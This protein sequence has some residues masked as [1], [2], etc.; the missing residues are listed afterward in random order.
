MP[1]SSDF[2]NSELSESLE[3]LGKI[4]TT[5][6]DH[7]SL[8]QWVWDG[9]I[10]CI[11]CKFWAYVE[12]AGL[13]AKFWN[14]TVEVYIYSF[15]YPLTHI[16]LIL[17]ML[18]F[19][20]MADVV[21]VSWLAPCDT[22][23][24][25]RHGAGN[26]GSGA[27]LKSWGLNVVLMTEELDSCG[28]RPAVVSRCNKWYLWLWCHTPLDAALD[29]MTVRGPP[30]LVWANPASVPGSHKENKLRWTLGQSENLTASVAVLKSPDLV[31][32]G[33]TFPK[34]RNKI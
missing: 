16:Q 28:P 26:R 22:E 33:L 10:M 30:D 2:S 21:S 3:G 18:I 11:P 27:G 5:E 4:W 15:S 31:A 7:N 24:G 32:K 17:F 29:S 34:Y 19:C 9:P 25:A 14:T 1:H 23:S 20:T 6:L 13:G 8:I 12:T